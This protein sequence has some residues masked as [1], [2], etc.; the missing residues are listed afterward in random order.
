MTIKSPFLVYQHFIK[1]E[2]CDQIA[3]EVHIK[4][5]KNDD[6]VFQSSEH[7]HEASEKIIFEL[8][9]PL[10]PEIEAHFNLT[11]R[12]TEHLVFQQFPASI[13]KPAEEPHCE[14]AVFKR[15]QWIKVKDRDLTG[16]LWLKDHQETPPFDLNKHVLGGKLEFP[17][18]TFGF[19]PQAGTLV[20]YPSNERFISLTSQIL[21]GELQ[22]VRFH[23]CAEGIWIY[24]PSEYKGDFR[25]WFQYVI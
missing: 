14:N 15:K 8:F 20:I 9:K 17:T 2:I 10:I 19:L 18:F 7:F 4:P 13:G 1:S 11:Y 25:T 12:G 23:I 24:Q 22:C 16:I 6:E 21:V 3:Q 5:L